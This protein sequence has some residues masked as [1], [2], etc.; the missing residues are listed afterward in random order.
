[1]RENIYQNIDQPLNN[2]LDVTPKPVIK[3]TVA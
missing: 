3:K 2:P 1:M